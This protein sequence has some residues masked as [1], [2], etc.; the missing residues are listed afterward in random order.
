MATLSGNLKPSGI[1][2]TEDSDL[3][4]RNEGC[5]D[6]VVEVSM[7]GSEICRRIALGRLRSKL[8]T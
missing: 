6:K 8:K 1:T 3:H 4:N 2:F 7:K 5:R